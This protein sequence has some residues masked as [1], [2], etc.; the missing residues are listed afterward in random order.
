MSLDDVT[1]KSEGKDYG[2]RGGYRAKDSRLA[3]TDQYGNGRYVILSQRD[4]R[5]LALTWLAE[6]HDLRFY[7]GPNG[8][9]RIDAVLKQKP[10]R[11][12]E[13][14]DFYRIPGKPGMAE[15]WRSSPIAKVT[16]AHSASYIIL[17]TLGGDETG[18]SDIKALGEPLKVA[19][20]TEWVVEEG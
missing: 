8:S 15:P 4:K 6:T 13:V 18:W 11:K 14:G 20:Q 7:P 10:V 9:R 16:K 12:P 17:E 5:E 19:V 2:N 3:I 1:F